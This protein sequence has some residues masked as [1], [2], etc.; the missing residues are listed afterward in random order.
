MLFVRC[1]SSFFLAL[2]R[3]L[4]QMGFGLAVLSANNA[5]CDHAIHVFISA[6]FQKRISR[7][8]ILHSASQFHRKRRNKR[9][10]MFVVAPRA[11]LPQQPL[12]FRS[13]RLKY[14]CN[15]RVRSVQKRGSAV[16][17]EEE[18]EE[19]A[20]LKRNDPATATICKQLKQEQRKKLNGVHCMMYASVCG[21]A[22]SQL[23]CMQQQCRSYRLT[24]V[25][26]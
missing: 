26:G 22:Q 1:R 25:V 3:D 6:H 7:L 9:F 20:V 11:P 17:Q 2:V 23:M 18:E 16:T 15:I 19:V 13:I 10:C 12:R 21:R 5:G 4:A 24:F 14:A 8:S